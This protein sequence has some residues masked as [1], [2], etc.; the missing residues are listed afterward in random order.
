M[1][2]KPA[3]VDEYLATVSVKERAELERLRQTIRKLLPKA[4]EC[5]SYAVPAF[6]LDGR[7]VAGFAATAKGFSYFPFSG[8]TLGTLAS[9][10]EG[11]HRTKSAL[12]FTAEKPLPAALV[13]K[14]LRARVAEGKPERNGRAFSRRPQG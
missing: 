14:L 11:Y 5:I 2:K 9:E 10:L 8:S 13:R 4:E 12:H 7:I 6:R 3:T 1:Q